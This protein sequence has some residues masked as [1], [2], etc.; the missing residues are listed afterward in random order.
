VPS[1][2]CAA[3]HPVAPEDRLLEAK[4]IAE[5]LSVPES[6]VRRETRAGRLPHISLGKYRRYDWPEVEAWLKT[7][8]GQ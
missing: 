5:L 4:E 7:K 8:Q 2:R 3:L 1:V 6:W